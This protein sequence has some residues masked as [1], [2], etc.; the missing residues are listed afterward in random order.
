MRSEPNKELL[1][2]LAEASGWTIPA[3][4]V[5]RILAEY[6]GI[7]KDSHNMLQFDPGGTDPADIFEADEQ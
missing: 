1:L 2:K 3:D 4:H 6:A 5:E 7:S